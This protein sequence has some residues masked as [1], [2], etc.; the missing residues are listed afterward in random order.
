MSE[1]LFGY[2]VE[3]D[4]GALIISVRGTFAE[5]AVRQLRERLSSGGALP[6]LTLLSPLVPIGRLLSARIDVRSPRGDV[7]AAAEVEQQALNQELEQTYADFQRQ[8]DEFRAAVQGLKADA[9]RPSARGVRQQ[10]PTE[11]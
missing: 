3:E 8:M 7:G 6:V 5:E 4:A 1:T 9:A 2:T 11:E 10:P